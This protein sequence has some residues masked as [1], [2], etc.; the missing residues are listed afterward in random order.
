MYNKNR[1]ESIY[2]EIRE[3]HRSFVETAEIFSLSVERI[4]QIC[5]QQDSRKALISEDPELYE[6]VDNDYRE[7]RVLLRN[8]LNVKKILSLY[9]EDEELNNLRKFKLMGDKYITHIKTKIV[10]YI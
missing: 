3:N 9:K 7:F 10:N 4:K 6:L 5:Q 2:N 8:G 1:N